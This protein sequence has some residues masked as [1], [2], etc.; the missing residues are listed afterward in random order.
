MK[1]YRK[2]LFVGDTCQEISMPEGVS[3]CHRDPDLVRCPICNVSTAGYLPYPPWETINGKWCRA[4]FCLG[5]NVFSLDGTEFEMT[6]KERDFRVITMP[7][8]ATK[9]HVR[10]MLHALLVGA[11][12]DIDEAW[13]MVDGYGRYKEC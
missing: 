2:H 11:G 6:Q 8:A 13:R 12:V 7:E 3:C 4:D 5:H 10:W 9:D 1:L